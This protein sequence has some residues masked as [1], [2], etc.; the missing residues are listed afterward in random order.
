MGQKMQYLIRNE[1]I[2]GRNLIVLSK[3]VKEFEATGGANGNGGG[4]SEEAAEQL[5]DVASKLESHAQKLL[6]I[7]ND[8]SDIREHYAKNDRVAEMKY[9]VDTINPM[10]FVTLRQFDELLEKKLAKKAK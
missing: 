3:R 8:V 1:K 5:R 10:D 4:F 9:V 2:L 7:Q 6:E